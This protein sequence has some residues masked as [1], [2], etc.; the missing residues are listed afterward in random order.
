MT[1]ILCHIEPVAQLSLTLQETV[2]DTS[3]ADTVSVTTY[4]VV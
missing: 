2:A 4:S 3:R 1:H